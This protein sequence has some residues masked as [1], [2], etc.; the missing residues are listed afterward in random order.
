MSFNAIKNGIS[1]ADNWLY[2]VQK[3]GCSV[4]FL[5]SSI[6]S[7]VTGFQNRKREISNVKEDLAFQEILDKQKEQY[8][9]EKEAEEIAFKIWLKEQQRKNKREETADKFKNELKEKELKPYYND[10]TLRITIEAILNIC[11]QQSFNQLTTIIG[12]PSVIQNE[13]SLLSKP[14]QY[15]SMV[16]SVTATLRPMSIYRYKEEACSDG[17]SL[18]YI[19]SMMSTIPCVVIMPLI[20]LYDKTI[21][22]RV[23]LWNQDSSFPYQ[24]SV[25]TLDYDE[26]KA[27][28]DRDY[29]NNIKEELVTHYLSIAWVLND[30]YNAI[31]R[32]CSPT[33]INYAEMN[34]IFG[35]YPGIKE[36]VYNEYSMFTNPA[37]VDLLSEC[38]GKEI[39]EQIRVLFDE[40]ISKLI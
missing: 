4:F 17:P 6:I 24:R 27:K 16:D 30:I 13:T 19:Y 29:L 15:N 10:W 12:K 9:N 7:L 39:A 38:Q 8:E 20:N 33:F 18:A 23:A 31:E 1:K 21:V 40:T 25:F 11:R 5:T 3:S 26:N 14:E 2:D 32:Q 28:N 22:L 35:K 37:R 36:F 34:S